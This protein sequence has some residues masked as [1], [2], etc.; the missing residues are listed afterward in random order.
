MMAKK[1]LVEEAS[2]AVPE[3]SVVSVADPPS[4]LE[5]ETTSKRSKA[6]RS[7]KRGPKRQADRGQVPTGKERPGSQRFE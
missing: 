4:D 6:K 1:D 7:D 3:S 5:T 2:T